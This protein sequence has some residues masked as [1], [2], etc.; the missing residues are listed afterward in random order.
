MNNFFFSGCFQSSFVRIPYKAHV[1]ND[2]HQ[3]A[4]YLQ[5]S[6]LCFLPLIQ[7]VLKLLKP[8]PLFGLDQCGLFFLQGSK[9]GA[10]CLTVRT[11]AGSCQE[12]RAQLS[13]LGSKFK[14]GGAHLSS[15]GPSPTHPLNQLQTT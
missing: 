14:H 10:E 12:S 1:D 8:S 9:R 2:E 7:K 5:Y 13:S 4:V 15:A 3:A 11:P 6:P